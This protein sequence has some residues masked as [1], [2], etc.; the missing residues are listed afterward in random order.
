[1]NRVI[2][3]VCGAATALAI[4]AFGLSG[5][6]APAPDTDQAAKEKLDRMTKPLA[7][8]I[9]KWAKN[10]SPCLSALYR[11]EGQVKLVRRISPTE[12]KITVVLAAFDN[13]VEKWFPG[14]DHYL[15]IYLRYCDGCWTTVRSKRTWKDGEWIVKALHSLMLTIDELGGK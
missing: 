11:Y 13:Q 15:T 7:E 4:L 6:T 8:T 14:H 9:T 5:R 1:M 12:A 3:C 10:Y 2:L